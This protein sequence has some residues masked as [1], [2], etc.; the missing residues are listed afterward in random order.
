MHNFPQLVRESCSSIPQR[1]SVLSGINGEG[2]ESTGVIE[3]IV[4]VTDGMEDLGEVETG[5]VVIG[6]AVTGVGDAS[7]RSTVS[8]LT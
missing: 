4:S 5:L 3:F 2:S 7:G 6:L 1:K 8:S